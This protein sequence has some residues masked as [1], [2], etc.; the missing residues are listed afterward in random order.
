MRSNRFIHPLKTMLLAG[1]FSVMSAASLAAI[2][3]RQHS[4]TL[5][6][7][8]RI[9][10]G[11]DKAEVERALGEPDTVRAYGNRPGSVTWLY[12]TATDLGL[13]GETRFAVE[14]GANGKVQ[15]ISQLYSEAD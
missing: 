6:E 1:A 14:F 2:A 8:S 12:A 11:A 4:I 10:R 5:D 7:I 15:S 13:R 3:P 9:P